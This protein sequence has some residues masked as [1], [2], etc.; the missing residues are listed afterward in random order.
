[1]SVHHASVDWL[2]ECLDATVVTT[3]LQASECVPG[4][5]SLSA[6]LLGEV[7]SQLLIEKVIPLLDLEDPTRIAALLAGDF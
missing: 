3:V 7:L 5:D 4:F 1:M 6:R 2:T